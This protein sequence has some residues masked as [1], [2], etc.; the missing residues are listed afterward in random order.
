MLD[1]RY[2]PIAEVLVQ[3]QVLC[4]AIALL[5]SVAW[6]PKWTTAR[7]NQAVSQL[8][9]HCSIRF[10]LTTDKRDRFCGDRHV[11]AS[12][13]IQRSRSLASQNQ[14]DRLLGLIGNFARGVGAMG[15]WRVRGSCFTLWD[16]SREWTAVANRTS[17]MGIQ[18]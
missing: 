11:S 5:Q 16:C 4:A 9:K 14:T 17:G 7:Q 2:E 12:P 13:G 3:L 1:G 15:S 18:V 8:S 6:R 10:V